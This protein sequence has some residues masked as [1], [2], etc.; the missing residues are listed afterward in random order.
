VSGCR[1][2]DEGKHESTVGPTR[3]GA[4]GREH[5]MLLFPP[6]EDAWWQWPH[7]WAPWTCLGCGHC[8]CGA[9][10]D[11]ARLQFDRHVEGECCAVGRRR[12]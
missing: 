10:E 3:M 2:C 5:A 7:L 4:D 6:V 8:H 11:S 9:D 1:A 12:A